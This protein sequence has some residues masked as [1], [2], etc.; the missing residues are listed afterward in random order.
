MIDDFKSRHLKIVLPENSERSAKILLPIVVEYVLN[1]LNLRSE[2]KIN[3]ITFFVSRNE[4]D[5]QPLAES[6]QGLRHKL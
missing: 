2:S 4:S 5:Y 3:E 6:L 1:I